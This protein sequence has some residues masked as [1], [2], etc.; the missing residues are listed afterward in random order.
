MLV[1]DVVI[2][3]RP[4]EIVTR[5]L[6]QLKIDAGQLNQNSRPDVMTATKVDCIDEICIYDICSDRLTSVPSPLTVLC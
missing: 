6:G 4:L 1:P 2:D 3:I 5:V